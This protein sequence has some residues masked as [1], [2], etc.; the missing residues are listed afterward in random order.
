VKISYRQASRDDVTRQFR[1]YLLKLDLPEVAVRFKEAV[2]KTAK[3][4]GKQ[5]GAAPPYRLRN[6]QL[7]NLRSW[8]VAGFEAIRFYFLAEDETIR[9]IRILHGK[10]NIHGILEQ[11]RI[12]EE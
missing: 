10:R 11:E 12:A 3:A 1:Y 8:P 9:V 7:Q 4:I 5:P 6:P 2:R